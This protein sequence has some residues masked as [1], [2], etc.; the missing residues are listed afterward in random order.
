MRKQDR[1]Q[2]KDQN[3]LAYEE[4]SGNVFADLGLKD[5]D[6]LFTRAQL[7]FHVCAILKAGKL[8]RREIAI[9]LGIDPPEVAHLMNGHYHRFTTDNL[10]DFLKRLDRKITIH[11]SPRV[12]GEPFQ[13]VKVAPYRGPRTA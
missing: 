7:G 2:K 3:P 13:V 10:L 6:A 9:L 12:S 11:I 5:A 8:K 4:G 1:H